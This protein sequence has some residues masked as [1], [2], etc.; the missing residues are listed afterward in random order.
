MSFFKKHLSVCIEFPAKGVSP[1]LSPQVCLRNRITSLSACFS[2]S[3]ER[4]TLSVRPLCWWETVHHLFIVVMI[5]SGHLTV[6]FGPS[7]TVYKAPSV[8]ITAISIILSFSKFKPV[9]SKSI[10]IKGAFKF[11]ALGSS[12]GKFCFSLLIFLTTKVF[13]CLTTLF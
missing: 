11:L 8:T 10:Q 2:V 7:I 4:R 5:S 12:G 1:F 3:W 9:I 6:K 13:F